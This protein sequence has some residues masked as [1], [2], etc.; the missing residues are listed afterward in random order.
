MQDYPHLWPDMK[1]KSHHIEGFA[2]AA[3]LGTNVSY[4]HAILDKDG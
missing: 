1:I 3:C 4:Y 2:H